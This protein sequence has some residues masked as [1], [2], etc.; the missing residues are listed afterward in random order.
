[1]GRTTLAGLAAAGSSAPT[2]DQQGAAATEFALLVPVLVLLVG[3]VVGGA[4]VWF[5]RA[6]VEQLAASSAR[7]A[8]VERTAGEAITGARRVA[9]QQAAASGLR[10]TTLSVDVSADGFSVPVG[11]PASVGVRVRC[12][13]PLS[14]VFV[15][16]WPGVLALEAVSES[17]LDRYRGRGR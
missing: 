15:P 5:A 4:R 6:S 9:S 7:A 11:T 12:A 2:R 17:A 16:G 13:V 10:C 1:M 3:L 14:D 8:S